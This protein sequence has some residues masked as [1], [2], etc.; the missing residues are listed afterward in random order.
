MPYMRRSR[1]WWG[2]HG[3]GAAI[4]IAAAVRA[5]AD[6]PG[7]PGQV[8]AF[9]PPRTM[10]LVDPSAGAL[11]GGANARDR[12]LTVIN[13]DDLLARAP[14]GFSHWGTVWWFD[15]A[16]ERRD[17][18]AAPQ[19][20]AAILSPEGAD[21]IRA[22]IASILRAHADVDTDGPDG[23]LLSE[24]ETSLRGLIPGYE[25]HMLDSY[26]RILRRLAQQE[27]APKNLDP[28]ISEALRVPAQ[29]IAGGD[30]IARTR[31]ANFSRR[32]RH[33]GRYAESPYGGS[34]AF[35]ADAEDLDAELSLET[36]TER[37]FPVTLKLQ[38][39]SWTAPE[40]LKVH[41]QF[42]TFAT[43]V[44][45]EAQ[46]AALRADPGVARVSLSRG[47]GMPDLASALPQAKAADANLA[48]LF[49][50][51]HIERG[52][53]ALF[54]LVDT[55]IDFLHDT[56][57]D[58]D[59]K[60]RIL[61]IWDQGGTGSATPKQVDPAFTQDYG[62]LYLKQDLEA[63]LAPGL[64]ELIPPTLRDAE[65]GH[66]T[67]VASIGAG[68][69]AGPVP[70][71][72]APAC[73]IV[74]VIPKITVDEDDP[75]SIGYSNSHID[76]IAFL[77]RVAAGST[78]VLGDRRPI[79]INVSLGMNAGAHDGKSPLEAAFDSLTSIGTDPGLAIV[80]SAGNE[81]T[82]GG[83]R[84]VDV[85][86]GGR[87]NIVW[88]SSDTPR[89]SDYFELWFDWRDDIDFALSLPD[90]VGGHK[91]ALAVTAGNP[92][93]S[94]VLDGNRVFMYLQRFHPDNGDHLLVIEVRR[95]AKPI[96]A[97]EWRLDLTGRSIGSERG[98]VHMWVERNRAR[99]VRFQTETEEFTLSVPATAET[100]ITVA[101][102]DREAIPSALAF[103][104]YGLTRIGGAKPD[105]AAPGEN[106]LAAAAG[107]E[108]QDAAVMSGTSMACPIITGAVVLAFAKQK[109][110]GK[111]LSNAVQIKR[112]LAKSTQAPRLSHNHGLGWGLINIRSFLDKI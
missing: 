82:H 34:E 97:G 21:T 108:P 111:Q 1:S 43:A 11:A 23:P 95:D 30:A 98:T 75:S 54:G 110:E 74:A 38:A 105:I 3:I 18:N 32:T 89:S 107:G 45:T 83:H 73:M 87:T 102:C 85:P 28:A 65:Q 56:F 19:G 9:G 41:S 92:E 81:R 101:A 50:P 55:G 109:R 37:L 49:P 6:R 36:P 8:Y 78:K 16:G 60:L 57:K 40:G 79:A 103:S 20:R 44:A 33:G 104:S 66:G 47:G 96:H 69:G 39:Q 91:P 99:A 93:A 90:E 10:N 51:D 29:E 80:K 94:G 71:G 22:D 24:R 59:G 100:V 84:S 25:A 35:S 77:K 86:A 88:Q 13:D 17:F 31:P 61:C 48:D 64:K 12:V 2:G 63:L 52:E 68:R 42:N 62:R 70:R 112:Y 14:M 76:A 5:W 72:V 7:Q 67:H 27:A 106:I 58:A 15:H 46:L 53:G 4:G 26:I